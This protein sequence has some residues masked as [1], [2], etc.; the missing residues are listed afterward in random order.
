MRVERS[1]RSPLHRVIHGL[2]VPPN[3]LGKSCLDSSWRVRTGTSEP[4]PVENHGHNQALS[5]FN[6]GT[7]EMKYTGPCSTGDLIPRASQFQV[8]T[9]TIGQHCYSLPPKQ[10][11]RWMCSGRAGVFLRATRGSSK[12]PWCPAQSPPG[13]ILF[14]SHCNRPL[15]PRGH[16]KAPPLPP[17]CPGL[18]QRRQ[19]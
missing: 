10:K 15:I 18:L 12:W 5:L 1:L 14:Y 17:R 11:G 13:K 6:N 16:P 2:P 19:G 7:R 9:L 4:V 8:P 3:G